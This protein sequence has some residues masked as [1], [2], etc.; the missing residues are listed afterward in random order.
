MPWSPEKSSIPPKRALDEEKQ[1]LAN[2]SHNIFVASPPRAAKF[3]LGVI[4]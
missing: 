2:K 1:Q 3:I 4:T